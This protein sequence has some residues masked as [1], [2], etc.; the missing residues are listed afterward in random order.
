MN[1]WNPR[2]DP[3]SS[4]KKEGIF[5]ALRDDIYNGVIAKGERIPPLRVIANQLNVTAVTV[6]RAFDLAE[7]SGLIE[8]HVGKGT[9]VC[10][11]NHRMKSSFD[12]QVYDLKTNSPRFLDDALLRASLSTLLN[13]PNLSNLFRYQRSEELIGYKASICEWSKLHGL[14]AFPENVVLT[15]GAQ[16]AI[17][18]SILA[19]VSPGESIAAEP[20]TYSGLISLCKSLGV[21]LVP[22][23][24]DDDGMQP[25]ALKAAL[26]SDKT[27]RSMFVV[28][29]VHNPT[30]RSMS[31]ARIQKLSEIVDQYDLSVIEDDN[32]IGPPI[33]S[34]KPSFAF[35]NPNRTFYV[36][37]FSKIIQPGMRIGYVI[38]PNDKAPVTSSIAQS[39]NF[40][41]SP[42]LLE[43]TRTWIADGTA[44]SIRNKNRRHFAACQ[45]VASKVLS[46][47]QFQSDSENAQLWLQLPKHWNSQNFTR[48]MRLQ[49]IE[50][51]P[52]EAFLVPGQT[53]EKAAVRLTIGNI[54]DNTRLSHALKTIRNTYY[55]I[56]P[57]EEYA[58]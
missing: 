53:L 10:L 46:G 26:A 20:L 33:S 17:A 39:L 47:L 6:K 25:Q 43:L 50:I 15:P 31:S 48:A 1:Q 5:K 51:M 14:S 19:S 2:M 9:F 54:A 12:N 32:Y 3:N 38:A 21:R 28:P 44:I 4:S 22:I 57:D 27:I 42:L 35:Y 37:G 52:G 8:R 29:R 23:P 16:A 11:N 55:A 13:S 58:P 7:Q 36:S 34:E 40:S 41:I 56:P 18:T 24:S 45:K 30:T 49:G